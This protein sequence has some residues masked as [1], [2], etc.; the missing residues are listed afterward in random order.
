MYAARNC[1]DRTKYPVLASEYQNIV[2]LLLKHGADRNLL[3]KKNKTA[4]HYAEENHHAQEKNL[5]GII[6]LL[7]G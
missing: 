2:E 3:D 5:D 1:P 6:E 7:R 4:L